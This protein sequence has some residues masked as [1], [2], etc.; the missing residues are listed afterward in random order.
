MSFLP[1]G[2]CVKSSRVSSSLADR[3]AAVLSSGVRERLLFSLPRRQDELELQAHWF[4]GNFGRDFTTTAGGA[5]RIVQFGVWNHEAGP[6]FSHAAVTFDGGE[7][8]CGAIEL[9]QDVRDWERHG[10]AQN[11][12]YESV[13]LHV[14]TQTGGPEFFTRTASHR[15]IPQVLLDLSQLRAEPPGALP[16]ATLGHCA[17]P[18]A[19]MPLERAREILHG[20]AEHR[21][22][23]KAAAL[24][25]LGQ[26]HGPDEALFQAI[27]AALG[28]KG[29]KL[30]FTLLS[31]RLPLRQLSDTPD[32]VEALLFGLG[33]FLPE[34]QLHDFDASTREYL[35][36]LWDRW[37]RRRAELARL[38]IPS[39]HWQMSGHRPV[40]HPHRR[41]AALAQV[42]RHWPKLRRAADRCEMEPLEQFFTGLSHPYWDVHYTLSSKASPK[43]MALVG[44]SRV[45]EILLNVFLPL[46]AYRDPRHLEAFLR[47]RAAEPS[48]RAE[49]AAMRLFGGHAS[50][51]EL[52]RSAAIQQGLLQV[53]ED[54]CLQD[55]SDCAQCPFPRQ[56]AHW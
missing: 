53:Y 9:D 38:M 30:P 27:A 26:A 5:V 17:A 50:R 11:P 34:R 6:D 39:D 24:A 29:N 22:R 40:N 42:V 28:Y 36:D 23:R 13:I 37:W 12:A 47:L 19:A 52:L 1:A 15:Q 55:A 21:L 8:R 18:L 7:P 32:E 4:A 48:R 33:G 46:F 2:T 14:C 35:R 54:F 43:A 56:L 31:Q 41:V 51:S 16:E 25:R 45:T 49:V 20:A 44:P 10:H 3:Y